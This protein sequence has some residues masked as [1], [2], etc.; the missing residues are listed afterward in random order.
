MNAPDPTV[1]A[2]AIT[3]SGVIVVALVGLLSSLLTAGITLLA[4]GHDPTPTPTATGPVTGKVTGP[5]TGPV[6]VSIDAPTGQQRR[7]SQLDDF[8][9]NILDQQ[10]NQLV[11]LFSKRLTEPDGTPATTAVVVADIGPCLINGTR[12]SCNGVRTG[13]DG[14]AGR[15]TY[16]IWGTVVDPGQAVQ[17]VQHLSDPEIGGAFDLPQPLHLGEAIAATDVLRP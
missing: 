12:W 2:A 13:P 11:W 15:G 4:T 8:S 6:T 9:G 17:I 10:K 14:N 1:Q 3:R 16:R 7:I 5:V